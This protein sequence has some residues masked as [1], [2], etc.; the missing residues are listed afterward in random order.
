VLKSIGFTPA[1]VVTSYVLL[2]AIPALVGCVTG[3]AFGNLLAIP[4]LKANAHVDP[5]FRGP[6][7]ARDSHGRRGWERSC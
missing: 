2:V 1:Q 7:G 6:C 3:A 4:L 5:G